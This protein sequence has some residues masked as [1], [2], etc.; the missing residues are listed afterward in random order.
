MAH[1]SAMRN[2]TRVATRKTYFCA[3]RSSSH[4]GNYNAPRPRPGPAPVPE[5]THEPTSEPSARNPVG[6][7]LAPWRALRSPRRNTSYSPANSPKGDGYRDRGRDRKPCHSDEGAFYRASA[8]KRSACAG[9]RA[10]CRVPPCSRP[11]SWSCARSWRRR[12]A[13]VGVRGARAR[14]RARGPSGRSPLPLPGG[15]SVR[16]RC[17]GKVTITHRR[18]WPHARAEAIKWI[19]T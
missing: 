13:G 11:W 1:A 16:C 17:A 6:S 19:R 4:G 9:A 18:P 3:R 14:A 5:R 12:L 10:W 2:S 8:I 15:R 7:S